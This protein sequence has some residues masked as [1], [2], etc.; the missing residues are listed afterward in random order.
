ML[1]SPNKRSMTLGSHLMYCLSR[2]TNGAIVPPTLEDA[3]PN[4]NPLLL[5]HLW[6]F[7]SKGTFE[8][9]YLKNY[10]F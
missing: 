5:L 1:D 10:L 3:E 7:F 8:Q 9:T 2:I 4:P 6:L